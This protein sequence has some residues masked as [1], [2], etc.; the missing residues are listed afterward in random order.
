MCGI[1]GV[2]NDRLACQKTTDGIYILKNRGQDA[3]GTTNGKK[4]SYNSQVL[5]GNICLG[6]VLHSVVGTVKQPI[7]N[8]GKLIS[9]CEIYNW[10]ELSKKY[11][12]DCENDS[13]LI[14]KLLDRKKIFDYK[15]LEEL[16]GVWAFAYLRDNKL[17][18]SRDILGVKPL[19]YGQTKEK[20]FVFASEKKV[21]KKL[22][23][24]NFN[25]LNPRSTLIYDIKSKKIRFKER[26]FISFKKNKKSKQESI[27]ETYLKLKNAIL[28][29]VPK[30]KFGLLFS[31]GIDSLIIAK[32]LKNENIDFTCYFAHSE[33]NSKDLAFV[34]ELSKE[35]NLKLKIISIKNKEI[36]KVIK[37]VV[38]TIESTNPIKIGVALPIYL[39]S[40]QAKKDKIKVLIS[41]LGADELFA[42]YHRFKV[43]NNITKDSVDLLLQMHENDLYRDDLITMDNTIE[44]RLPYLDL[45]VVKLALETNDAYKINS[46]ENKIIIREIGKKLKLNKK[47]FKRKKVAAQYGSGFDKSLEKLSK[48]NN[49]KNK[50]SYLNSF[51]TEK[52]LNVAVLYSGGKDSNLALWIMKRQNYN[53][54][55][56]ISI[57][58]E[59]NDSY[60]YQKPDVSVLKKQAKALEVPLITKKTKGIKEEELKELILALKNAKT[61]YNIQGVVSGALF[62]NY[63][64]ERIQKI[65]NDLGLRMFSPLWHKKQEDELKELLDNGFQIMIV[66]IAGYGMS[67][68][69][70]GK[71]INQE[72]LRKL[73]VLNK[74]YGF[75][76]AG[77]GGEYETIVVDAPTFKKKINFKKGKLIMENEFTGY[78]KIV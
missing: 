3:V 73:K 35:Y 74:K 50:S 42:G 51:S 47:Y 78:L 55:C 13:E 20:A 59:S 77:E 62:S 64:R 11:N 32:I 39:A 57:V 65:C 23:C 12:I 34:K 31:G 1:I 38:E 66:K 67:K 46:E 48:K 6:H 5:K 19:W 41:G 37:H 8:K 45:E 9:N 75:N 71:I 30:T 61:K 21:L 2:L 63:Q 49:Y 53:I 54:S 18:L 27:S 10:K 76:V 14:L 60:M 58:P 68:E 40:K 17:Y 44:L 69:W 43:S 25:F 70:L 22:N 4:I 52:N 56:L 26:K 15:I 28:S 36:P 29:R 33:E 24:T 7:S 16:N 72:D